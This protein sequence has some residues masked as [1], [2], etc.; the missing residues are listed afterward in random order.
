VISSAKEGA[1]FADRTARDLAAATSR[2][3]AVVDLIGDFAAQTN[4]LT[5]NATIEAAR[6][7]ESGRGFAV[8]A[9]EVNQL[10]DQTTKATVEIGEQIGDIQA[11]TNK[12]AESTSMIRDRLENLSAII[13]T[14]EEAVARQKQATA[15]IALKIGTIGDGSRSATRS[16]AQVRPEAVA[17]AQEA[18]SV[19][20][21]IAPSVQEIQSI[22]ARLEDFAARVNAA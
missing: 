17:T 7:G 16:T 15:E 18:N 12:P 11:N 1:R 8:V 6:A 2:I 20:A 13:V 14:V 9:A 19:Y 21:A 5:L 10:A 4:L 3:G 22:R